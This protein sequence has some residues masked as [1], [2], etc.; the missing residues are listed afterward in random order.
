MQTPSPVRTGVLVWNQ[1][2]DWPAMSAAA[3]R[4]DE[5]GYDSL[6][7]WD[8]LYPIIGDPDGPFLEGWM[9]VAGWSQ[10]TSRSTIGLLVGANTFR[11]PALV[12]K[13]ATTLDHL[14][15]G[16][17]VLGIG[18]A[19]FEE[20]HAA[21]GI[22]FGRS[23]G[24]RID[25]LDEA[26]ELM[27]TMLT[28]PRASARGPRYEARDVRNLPAPIQARLPILIGGAGE[29][30][31]LRTVARFADM[32]NVAMVTPDEAA[33]KDEVLRRWCDEVGRDPGE[34]ER[35][36]SLG[37]LL[38][39]DDPAEV[40]AWIERYHAANPG[41]TRPILSG[42][43]QEIAERAGEYVA[44]G[45]RHLIYHLPQPYDDET[46]QRFAGEVRPALTA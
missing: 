1:Y 23:F 30:K 42:T 16:R 36:V 24:E 44:Q 17:A 5:L 18:A 25:W 26:V 46:L 7:T 43:P 20:E 14:S 9:V 31:T 34:I 22:E 4:V 35:T 12:A 11:N 40:S 10:V 3:R 27:R 6:W 41:A 29:R 8:H 2:T 15:A 19:W 32:W 28:E 13:M 21:F 45:F 37:P 39:R 33:R 38:I